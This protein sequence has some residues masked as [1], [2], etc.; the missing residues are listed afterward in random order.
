M[1]EHQTQPMQAGKTCSCGHHRVVP[2]VI[3]L[4]G[5]DFLLG[6]LNVFTMN[7]VNVSWPI[8]VIIAGIVKMGGGNC[9]CCTAK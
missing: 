7:F 1:M 8:L 9:K 2:I 6:Q 4:I 3:I 5:L